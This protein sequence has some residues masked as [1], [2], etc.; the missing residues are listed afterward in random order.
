MLPTFDVL[1]FAPSALAFDA[2]A[3]PLPLWLSLGWCVIAGALAAF[4]FTF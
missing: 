4:T 2:K 3:P 1:P